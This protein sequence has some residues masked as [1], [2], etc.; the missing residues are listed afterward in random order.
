MP[1]ARLT[2][3]FLNLAAGETIA[4]VLAFLAMLVVARRVGPAMY[5]VIGVASGIMLY[6]NQLADAGA[7]LAGVP[8]V[9]RQREGL[10]ELVSS[11]LSVRLRIAAVLTVLVVIVGLFAFPQPDGSILAL[12]ALSLVFVA[13]G[14]R[15][16]FVGMQQAS[17][18]ATARIVG[19]L[20]SLV[21]VVALLRDV[22]EV[23]MVP[24]ASLVGGA[25]ATGIMLY[26][27]RGVGVR[28]RL[29]R[30]RSASR[31]LLARGPH[32]VGFTLLGLVLFNADLIFLRFVSGQAAAGY[33][34]AAYT[35][36]AFSA[37]LSVAWAH[38]VMPSLSRFERADAQRGTV[39]Q[40]SMLLAYLVA[41]PVAVGGILTAGPLID[42][43]FGVEYAPAATA[44]AWL[45]PAVPIAAVREI[46]VV[47]L[48]GSAG[49]EK[50]LIRI[51]ATCA[52]FNV[53]ILLPVVPVYGMV[54]AAVVTVLTE[55]LRLVLA[56]RSARKEEFR[57]PTVARFAKPAIAAA[58]MVPALLLTGSQPFP[59]LLG[60][61]AT[62]YAAMLLATGVLRLGWP[63]RLRLVV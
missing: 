46:A 22:G 14:T 33:Y 50:R 41:L 38:S 44:L 37:N 54:G 42:L 23:A 27:L 24:I 39:Y 15:W 56:F 30:D 12:Y 9:A 6:L 58:A 31:E 10:S 7:E 47:A 3:S 4:R 2:R 16:V 28:P 17:W 34:A 43:I 18:V 29:T 20:T 45:L 35:F 60:L 52:I 61:G 53:A 26:A 19:E 13:L 21:L 51:N 40:T 11:A 1:D 63:L 48:I 25:V 36:I 59:V 49:G 8:V 5:G 32:L 62:V 55:V 57:F